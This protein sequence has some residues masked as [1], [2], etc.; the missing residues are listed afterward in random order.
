MH[1][2]WSQFVPNNYVNPTSEDIKLHIIIT[3]DPFRFHTFQRHE[4]RTRP[5]CR[6]TEFRPI[7]V[8]GMAAVHQS[9]NNGA[10]RLTSG[11]VVSLARVQSLK[12]RKKKNLKQE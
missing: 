10:N 11:V 2:H 5:Y 9:S 12:L 1:T 3:L 8:G 6:K 4:T 7:A